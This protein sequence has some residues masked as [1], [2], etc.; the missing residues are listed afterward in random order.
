MKKYKQE[1]K[2]RARKLY[3]EGK[4]THQVGKILRIS[5]STVW[6]WCKDIIRT[7]KEAQRGKMSASYKGRYID[8]WKKKS[9]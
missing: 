5:N 2:D 7:P 8:Q 1:V 4:S 3:S 6:K 9:E